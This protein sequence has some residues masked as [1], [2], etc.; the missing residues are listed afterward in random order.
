MN[1]ALD[2]LHMPDDAGEYADDLAAI[3]TRIPNGWGRW[4][5]VGRGW[6]Q[7]IID[8][9]HHLAEINPDYAVHQVKEKFGGLRYYIDGVDYGVAAPLV[10]E[11]ERKALVTCEMCGKPAQLSRNSYLYKTICPTCGPDYEPIEEGR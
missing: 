3:M 11:A 7:L 1:N 5:G 9:D 6:Y 8:L 2:A 4:I 10:R